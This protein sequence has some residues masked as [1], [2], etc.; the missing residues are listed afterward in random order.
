MSYTK[1]LEDIRYMY[2]HDPLALSRLVPSS[3]HHYH[4]PS[5]YSL[6]LSVK[7]NSCT[8]DRPC[9]SPKYT[10]FW[11]DN[12]KLKPIFIVATFTMLKLGSTA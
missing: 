2:S 6:Y 11:Y 3:F 9:G 1:A 12:S 4:T 5:S 10:Q 7:Y 8:I